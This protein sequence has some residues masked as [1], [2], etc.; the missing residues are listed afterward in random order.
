M[1]INQ[2][3]LPINYN[4]YKNPQFL[5]QKVLNSQNMEKAYHKHP[6]IPQ[7]PLLH[8]KVNLLRVYT[9]K[10]NHHLK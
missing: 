6:L 3:Q 5:R 10:I 8:K 4:Y 7:N 2:N 1:I 9:N